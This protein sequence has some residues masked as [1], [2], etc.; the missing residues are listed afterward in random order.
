MT[1]SQVLARFEAWCFSFPFI[2]VAL[3]MREI[4]AARAEFSRD[5]LAALALLGV[6]LLAAAWV[7]I[8]VG[9][10]PL[11]ALQRSVLAVKSGSKRS[12]EVSG[13]KRESCARASPTIATVYEPLK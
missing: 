6:A 2:A 1:W 8:S 13:L 5:V 3:D 9:L 10:R 7:Q 4:K 12:I 11:K